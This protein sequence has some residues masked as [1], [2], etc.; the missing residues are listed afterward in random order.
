MPCDRIARCG[1]ERNVCL[2]A[3]HR[4][5]L[6]SVEE[7]R[8]YEIGDAEL[9]SAEEEKQL[10]RHIE[11]GELARK[12]LEAPDAQFS[13]EERED[14]E[15]KI[16][17]GKTAEHKFMLANTRLIEHVISKMAVPAHISR[18]DLF[19]KAIFGIHRAV[20][21]FD[22]R[23][24]F[25]FS[26][27][28][29]AWIRQAVLTEITFNTTIAKGVAGVKA[30]AAAAERASEAL[31]TLNGGAVPTDAELADFMGITVEQLRDTRQHAQPHVSF[32]KTVGGSEDSDLKLGDTIVDE[33][34]TDAFSSVEHKEQA[35]I[36]QEML[37]TIPPDEK[38]ALL[39]EMAPE[40][41]D[42]WKRT[43][44][45]QA[46]VRRAMSRLRHPSCRLALVAMETIR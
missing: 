5:S 13:D 41:P 1:A 6:E 9:L 37:E 45:H 23:R 25:K 19:Q 4:V 36:L 24:G 14:L 2:Q 12:A 38:D 10:A 11:A 18:A 46:A 21:K 22:W 17:R 15:E 27:Y 8:S 32:E 34:A 3:G 28:S 42:D 39:L 44:H 31:A 7:I 16:E 26:T 40:K 29:T 20:E 33:D 30:R 43:K 35:M